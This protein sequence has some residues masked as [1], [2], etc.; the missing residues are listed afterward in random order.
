MKKKLFAIVIIGMLV[1]CS[2]D[3]E[4][5]SISD[6]A[7]VGNAENSEM[8]SFSNERE[9]LCAVEALEDGQPI[10]RA[11]SNFKSLYDEYEAAWEIEDNYYDSMEKYEEFKK[12]FPH[13]YFPEYEDDYSFFLPISNENI[14][15][16]VN[17]EGNV[18]IDGKVVNYI[19]IKTPQDLLKL[20]K[21]YPG[22]ILTRGAV[23]DPALQSKVYMNNIPKVY[24]EE[25]DRRMWVETKT[26]MKGG[27]FTTV[28]CVHFNKKALLGG[29]K[30]Y[31]SNVT[32]LGCLSFASGYDQKFNI[33]SETS[34]KGEVQFSAVDRY[35]P[36]GTRCTAQRL[37][38]HYQGI[39]GYFHM[40]V[41]T[42]LII[43]K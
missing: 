27:Y 41:D 37:D 40:D 43:K 25:N 39:T 32:L 15:K 9:F 26:A 2:H 30:R 38:I 14:A 5:D 7:I 24:N 20:G 34:G 11:V 17:L 28:I 31:R 12:M 6:K 19:D 21:L 18:L 42:D 3:A 36:S 8:L 23:S 1:A 4:I 16:L 13:L 22:D 35:Q 10:S 33:S 29:W